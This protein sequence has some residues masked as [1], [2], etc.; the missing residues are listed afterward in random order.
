MRTWRNRIGPIGFALSILA[1]VILLVAVV[2]IR[3]GLLA[4]QIGLLKLLP[5]AVICALVAI[6]VSILALLIG[7]R[8]IAALIG[9]II[10]IAVAAP[11]L[12][13]YTIAQSV[14]HIH[15]ITTD[16]ADPPGFVAILPLRKNAPN[17][18]AYGGAAIA[19]QQREAYP[20][21]KPAAFADPPAQVFAAAVATAKSE[22]WNVVA[23]VPQEGRIEATDTTFWMGFTDDI[24]VRVKPQGAGTR[25]D[26]RSE[27]RVGRSD[28]GTN[29]RRI[30]SYLAALAGRLKSGG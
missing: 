19:A 16:T 24:V 2:G 23:E 27:S 12:R 21:L 6:V 7:R 29:A 22:G 8:R 1:V 13:Q 5:L 11:L 30:E 14:P 15:D 3:F 4:L 25:V 20:E 28:V 10:G 18:A 9:L 17:S 26:V